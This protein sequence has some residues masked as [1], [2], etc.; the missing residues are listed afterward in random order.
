M[1]S[2]PPGYL[3]AD[4]ILGLSTAALG[5]V[6]A[7]RW[8]SG[9]RWRLPGGW[10]LASGVASILLLAAAV[11][12]PLGILASHYL[13]T[14][15]L[16]QVTI[17]MGFVPPLFLLALPQRDAAP[18]PALERSQRSWRDRAAS[19]AAHPAV[20]IV[21]VNLVFFGWH[22]PVL[23]DA[24]LAHPALYSLQ[25]VSFL[26]VAFAFWWPIVEPAGGSGVAMGPLIK[27]GY[28]LLA[29]IPQTFAGLV[30]ALARRPFYS[31]YRTTD[32]GLSPLADQQIAGACMALL[33]KI[34][35]F[36]AFSV[37]L[38]RVLAP[39]ADDGDAEDSGGHGGDERDDHPRPACPGPPAWLELLDG[40]PTAEEPAP[41]TPAVS[42]AV[43]E[44][45]VLVPR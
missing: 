22:V 30:F 29:T 38:W 28:I 40:G 23:Y 27:L 11:L 34:A 16:L 18:T 17:L 7:W 12:S 14:A 24:S 15:H 25:Q 10:R 44:Q 2:A 21:L 5:V 20:A 41:T 4:P 39:A 1:G 26:M 19:L 6:L 13:L 36:V 32:A 45:P 31:G 3:D 33:S 43:A 8:R 35:L 42:T 9:G 37:V